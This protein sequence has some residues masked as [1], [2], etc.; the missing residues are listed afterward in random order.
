M[1]I[2]F[3]S[4]R[5]S[6]VFLALLGM[7]AATYSAPAKQTKTQSAE[8]VAVA[9]SKAGLPVSNIEVFTPKTDPNRLMGRPGQYISKVSFTDTNYPE[10]DLGKIDQTIETFPTTA[11][12]KT[13]RDYID[14]VTRNTPFLLQYQFLRGRVLLRL[15]KELSPD[16]AK[17]YEAALT[18]I[19]PA[20]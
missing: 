15:D 10:N 20:S 13:R 9:L 5:K 12:A 18:E 1:V 6:V 4:I 7:C 16:D 3:D 2:G 11:A 17:E 8:D 14:R 19:V